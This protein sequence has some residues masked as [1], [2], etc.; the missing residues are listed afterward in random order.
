MRIAPW[1][2][3]ALVA[4]GSPSA[5]LVDAPSSPWSQGPN[6]PVPRLEPGVTAMGQNVVVIG[7]FDTDQQAGLDV[8]KRVDVFDT[9][10]NA[11]SQLPDAPVARHHVQIA[12]I[13]TTIYLL[14]GLDGTPDGM[15][16]YPARGD[17]YAFDTQEPMATWHPL[18]SMP[19]GLERGS[20]AVVV[21]PPRIYLLGGASTTTAI[22]SN[23]YYD[24]IQDQWC[25]GLACT[26]DAQ[27]PNLPAARSHPAAMRKPDGTLV[28]IG[29]LS[30]LTSDTEADDVW[31]LTPDQ[32]LTTG[33]W[34]TTTQ[35]GDPLAPMP[36]PRGGCAYGIVQGKMMCVGGEAGTSALSYT[37][38]YD[39][40]VDTWTDFEVM[41]EPRAGTLGA[42]VSESLYIPGGARAIVFEPTD[43]L[44]IYSPLMP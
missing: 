40:L 34:S 5:P 22:A 26:A 32:Q 4:C 29:G 44:F 19:V 31:W 8:T 20:A 7:G 21:V 13:G 6:L 11:W 36:H 14:G 42:V 17:C 10:A 38:G 3:A 16:D 33:A 30:A 23:L 43:S 27:L 37:E 18:T 41:P 2:A 12:A 25:P 28:L 1:A 15:N 35:T 39:P 24:T 9:D